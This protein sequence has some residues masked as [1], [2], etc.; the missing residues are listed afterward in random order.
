MSADTLARRYPAA[1]CEHFS[2]EECAAFAR[3]GFVV[4]RNLAPTKLRETL[5][6]RARQQLV[7]AI[8]PLEYESDVH[9]PGAP[10]TRDAPGGSTVRRLLKAYGRDAAFRVWA[11]HPVLT[12]RIKQLLGNDVVLPQ[13]HH[14]CVMTKHPRYGSATLWHQDTR[15]WSYA[16]PDLINVWLA[17]GSER[18]DNGCLRLLP[19]SHR[20]QIE[21]Q[22]LDELQFLRTDL[23]MNQPLIEAQVSAELDPGDVLFFH[24]RVFHSASQNRST[25]TKFSLVYTYRASDNLP[26][27]NSRSSALPD[28][29]LP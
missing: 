12:G 14:N 20:M 6:E 7:A 24:A 2:A 22:Q 4:A 10:A 29:V 28:I 3:D 21:P 9:Y 26:L 25:R 5:L 15:Y 19:A 1:V 16:R 11:S 8:E 23:S 13:A 18:L 17:L 27:A